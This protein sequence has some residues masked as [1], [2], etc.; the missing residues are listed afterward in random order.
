MLKDFSLG[1]CMLACTR[2]VLVALSA[3]LGLAVSA[4]GPGSAWAQAGHVVLVQGAVWIDRQGE[5]LAAQQQ[6]PIQPADSLTTAVGAT[7]YV[8][9]ADGSLLV[10]RGGSTLLISELQLE[11]EPVRVRFHLVGGELRFQSGQTLQQQPDAFRVNTPVAAVGIRGTDFSVLTSDQESWVSIRSGRVVID[12]LGPDCLAAATGPCSSALAQELTPEQ[13]R[14]IR[15][16]PQGVFAVPA[17]ELAQRINDQTQR[18]PTPP[19]NQTQVLRSAS[20]PEAPLPVADTEPR[21]GWAR[22]GSIA[23]LQAASLDSIAAFE[24][25]F[26]TFPGWMLAREAGSFAW[27]ASPQDPTLR[28]GVRDFEAWRVLGSGGQAVASPIDVTEGSLVLQMAERR[29]TTQLRLQQDG[30][31]WQ[32]RSQGSVS[33]QGRLQWELVAGQPGSAAVTGWV[34]GPGA[35]DAVYAFGFSPAAQETLTGVVRWSRAP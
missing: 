4:L 29:F 3:A 16:N 33:E 28:F 15:V 30:L 13:G 23:Q 12:R 34:A 7:A 17:A 8:R 27:P 19:R 26:T 31:T 20:A 2:R 14:L 24:D 21:V 22:L 35:T 5:R 25:R 9:L 18:L 11:S 10:L 6:S 32:L 1:V